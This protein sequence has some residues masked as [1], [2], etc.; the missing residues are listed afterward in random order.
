MH[1][2]MNNNMYIYDLTNENILKTDFKFN[3]LYCI[4]PDYRQI[5]YNIALSI[6]P[7]NLHNKEENILYYFTKYINI[8]IEWI[9]TGLDEKAIDAKTGKVFVAIDPKYFR[10]TEVEV[11]CSNPEKIRTKL[12][13]QPK[14]TFPELVKIMMDHDLKEAGVN[15]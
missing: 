12:G 8:K 2:N 13:W 11:L 3:Y 9:G 7:E 6:I 10:P 4:V 5:P 14:T 15:I 1:A